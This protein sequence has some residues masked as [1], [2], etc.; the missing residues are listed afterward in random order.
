[1][2]RTPRLARTTQDELAGFDRPAVAWLRLDAATLDRRLVDAVFVPERIAIARLRA[3]VLY[4]EHADARKALVLLA[5]NREGA[6]PL[7]LGVAEGTD[8]DMD[9]PGAERL[10][11]IL[12]IVEPIV[13]K[14]PCTRS[15][16]DAK[17][18]GKA[19]Q[20]FLR[21]PERLEARIADADLQ[22]GRRR[23]PPVRR[24]GDMRCE[25]PDEFPAGPSIVDTQEYMSAVVRRRPR[26]ENGR[27]DFVQLERRRQRRNIVAEGFRDRRHGRS[28]ATESCR[29]ARRP[30]RRFSRA[31]SSRRR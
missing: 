15:H 9:L 16:A 30:P 2:N 4:A 8:T 31:S 19:V 23:I 18:L 24:G 11:P 1:R 29:A 3:E 12:R 21:Q 28:P 6:A 27:L 7:V 10:L 14:L 13:A 25:P 20:R 5:R 17:R 22:P 26:P